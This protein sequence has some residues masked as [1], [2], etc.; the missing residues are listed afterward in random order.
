VGT[1]GQGAALDISHTENA[2]LV[3]GC[4]DPSCCDR[5]DIGLARSPK[6]ERVAP[7]QASSQSGMQEGFCYNGGGSLWRLKIN[8]QGFDV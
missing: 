8:Y 6:Y 1:S 2:F 5:F 3:H 7:G 4:P